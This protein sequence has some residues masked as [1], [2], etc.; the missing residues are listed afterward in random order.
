MRGKP[1]RTI[2]G[3]EYTTNIRASITSRDRFLLY[4]VSCPVFGGLHMYV[5]YLVNALC[6][7]FFSL[8]LSFNCLPTV[9]LLLFT[10]RYESLQSG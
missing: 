8:L 10:F 3:T 7:F 1:D 5:A 2:G 4:C 9:P 6:C